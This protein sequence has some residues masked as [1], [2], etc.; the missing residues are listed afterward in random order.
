[1]GKRDKLYI[2]SKVQSYIR[3]RGFRVSTKV[4]DGNN[5]NDIIKTLLNK[6]IERTKA[7]RRK[8]VRP[9]D[10]YAKIEMPLPAINKN[11][12]EGLIS[13][14]KGSGIEK[15]GIMYY[16]IITLIIR[17]GHEEP[18]YDQIIRWCNVNIKNG[19]T[20]LD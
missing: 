15:R 18:D 3:A 8:I 17:H 7:N 13:E 20:F 16:D 2:K 12:L 9:Y 6:G 4:L 11:I 14:L 10:V 19:K 5:L 1:M